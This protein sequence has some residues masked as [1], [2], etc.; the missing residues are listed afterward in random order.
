MPLSANDWPPA[1]AQSVFDSCRKMGGDGQCQCLVI[2]LQQ[3]F[4]FEDM[5]LA[6]RNRFAKESLK[7][8]T[9]TFNMKCLDSDYKEKTLKIK[10][11]DA[12]QASG[13]NRFR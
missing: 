8:M 10:K 4:T 12:P 13:L 9:R 3:K 11:E 2:R 7:Q 6:M 1:M 5:S